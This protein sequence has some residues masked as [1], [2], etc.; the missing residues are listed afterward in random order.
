MTQRGRKGSKLSLAPVV[1][2]P[3]RPPPPEDLSPVEAEVWDRVVKGMRGDWFCSSFED[4]LRTYVFWCGQSKLIEQELRTIPV[5]DK[6]YAKVLGQLARATKLI[7]VLAVRLRLTP[8]QSRHMRDTYD[9][10]R[11]RMPKPWETETPA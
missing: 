4:L 8:Q 6:R 10:T 2:F 9:A 3:E 1:G 11:G 7:T 5:D